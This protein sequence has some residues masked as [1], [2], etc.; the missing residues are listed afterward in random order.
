MSAT[1]KIAIGGTAAGL[2]LFAWGIV[3]FTLMPLLRNTMRTLPSE[4]RVVDALRESGATAGVYVFPGLA[5]SPR[6]DA[7]GKRR[8][9]IDR[10]EK[11]RRGPIGLI[12]YDPHGI[13]PNRMFR[14]LARGL[15]MSLLAGGFA[16]WVLS[17]ARIAG[18]TRRVAFV[19]GMGLFGWL[20]GPG[21]LG[22]WFNYPPDY[23]AASLV[24][25]LVGWAI[26]GIVLT[27]I[28]RP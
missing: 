19:V 21:T 6:G 14:P 27:G 4:D 28:V 18:R 1:R 7:D 13:T 17:R 20:L 22:A 2:A 25:A 23:L 26:A 5:E 11:L 24:E 16:A 8:S 9:E 3:S 12:V 15:I 10:Q